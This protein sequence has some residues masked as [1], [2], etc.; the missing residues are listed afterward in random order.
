M[1]FNL[2][3]LFVILLSFSSCGREEK[4]VYDFPLEQ[5]LKSDKEVSLN[6]ELLAPYLM[7]SYD[8]TLCLIDWTANPMVHVYNMNT[9]KEMVAFGNKG[10]GPD[11]FLSI[12]QMYVDISKRSLVLYDQSLQTISSFQIDS[13]AQGSLSKI[14]CVS[15]PKLGMNRVY[16]YSDSIFYGSG[17]FESGLIAKCNQKEILNQ[18]L[19]FPQTEQAVNRD[20][21]YLL[22]RSYYEAG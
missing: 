17:T 11:D 1:R 4:T 5:S 16:A 21:N 3:V 10:M 18:Y 9:G 6:K 14:D 20:V 13:L 12:S 2:V 7:C 15:A 19:P 8:S 22:F